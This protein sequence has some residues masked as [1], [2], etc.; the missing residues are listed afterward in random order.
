[1]FLTIN[2][3]NKVYLL[4]WH[5]F[6]TI[7]FLSQQKIA[8]VL[9]N[10]TKSGRTVTLYSLILGFWHPRFLHVKKK[11]LVTC[12]ETKSVKGKARTKMVMCVNGTVSWTVTSTVTDC[13]TLSRNSLVFTVGFSPTSFCFGFRLHGFSSAYCYDGLS[14][15]WWLSSWVGFLSYNWWWDYLS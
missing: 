11:T 13:K 15:L 5:R 8:R 3:T 4:C 1:M 9:P 12:L 10:W 2:Y 14:V 6:L 7:D